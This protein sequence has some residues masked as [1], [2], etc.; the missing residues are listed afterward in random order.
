M[1]NPD[2]LPCR[3]DSGNLTFKTI[4]TILKLPF[5]EPSE[6]D[7]VLILEN[8]KKAFKVVEVKSGNYATPSLYGPQIYVPQ[9]FLWIRDM[10]TGEKSL[11]CFGSIIGQ[12]NYDVSWIA[13]RLLF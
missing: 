12:H 4:L 5:V 8:K 7:L 1:P 11:E 2:K 3:N 10:E 9:G 6:G 13:N